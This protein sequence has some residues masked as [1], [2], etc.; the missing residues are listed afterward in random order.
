ME[1]NEEE[2]KRPNVEKGKGKKRSKKRG[3][4]KE[5]KNL[6]QSLLRS[7]FYT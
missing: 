6:D 1:R 5:K 3:E 4:K 7:H 2:E